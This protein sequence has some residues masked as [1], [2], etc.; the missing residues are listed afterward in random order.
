VALT[1]SKTPEEKTAERRA[2]QDDVLMREVDDAV[3]QDEFATLANRYGRPLLALLV[4]GLLAF[5]GYLYWDH[6]QD[7]AREK[8]SE[9]LISALDKMQSGQ[10]EEA[11]STLDGVIAD[12]GDGARSVATM[13]KAGLA[14]Q[15]GRD[16]EA[17]TLFAEV[18]SDA[19]APQELRDLATLREVAIRF[20]RMKPDDVVARLKA[21]AV[22][23]SPYFG[24][25][26]EL[27]AIAYMEQGK[28]KEAGA[29]LGEIAKDDTVPETLRSRTRQLAGL[30]GVDAVGDVDKLL[31]GQGPNGAQ[32]GADTQP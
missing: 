2:A 10:M 15:S 1:P 24:S 18:S 31:E 16:G 22:P 14:E 23:G 8:Q 13:L 9:A 5:G 11:T 25:A 21:M 28:R 17:A 3:R 32:P 29:L 6:R 27:V 30:L 19:D 12:G 20:D 7:Q 4:V 26:G